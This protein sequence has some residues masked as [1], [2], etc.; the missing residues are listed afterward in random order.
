MVLCREPIFI[1]GFADGLWLPFRGEILSQQINLFFPLRK[2][3]DLKI[4]HNGGLYDS[5]ARHLPDSTGTPESPDTPD[6]KVV[7]PEI[8]TKKNCISTVLYLWQG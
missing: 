1:V 4:F 5:D 8:S 3:Q 6:S 7:H 2:Y